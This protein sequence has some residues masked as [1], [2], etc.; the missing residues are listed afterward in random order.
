MA[1]IMLGCIPF[2][3]NLL[4]VLS[5]KNKNF[6]K[7]FSCIYWNKH[8]IF[9]L[10]SVQFRH[11]VV[12]DSLWPHGLQHTRLPCPSPTPGACSNSCPLSHWCHPTISSSVIS[13]SCLQSFPTSGSFL[14]GQF[15]SSG[16]QSIGVSASASVLPMN[17]QDWFPLGLTGCISLQSKGLSRVFS[18]TT[19]Q[20]HQ[21]FG[22]QLSLQSN[23]HIH[24]WPLEKPGLW[25]DRPLFSSV[26]FSSVT[27]SCPT[28]C[29][30][31]NCSTPGLP[32]HHQLLEFTQTHVH[33]DGDAIQPSDP[34]SS[35]SPPVPNP[36]QHQ[37]LFQW[38][39]CSR[40]VAKVLEFQL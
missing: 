13:S 3:T 8:R 17:I 12:S 11:S 39:N 4:R 16:G 32:V 29:N 10:Q 40:E 33:R 24:T 36:S 14:V 38:V 28:L 31:M 30:P 2:I 37:S 5:W 15:F 23:S 9:T 20:K 25:L 21:F 22:T 26:Q 6:V 7:Y 19:V 1:F 27:Q 18:N 35:P 34:R